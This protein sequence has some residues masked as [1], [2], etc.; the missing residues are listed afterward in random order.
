MDEQRLGDIEKRVYDI[1]QRQDRFDLRIDKLF[2]CFKKLQK[3]VHKEVT[4]KYRRIGS[5]R[6]SKTQ[7]T[8]II[9]S[10]S[11]SLINSINQNWE[12]IGLP[13]D[14]QGYMEEIKME[15]IHPEYLFM[16]FLIWPLGVVLK[17]LTSIGN[18]W[19]PRILLLFSVIG[20]A[21][22]GYTISPYVGI[23]RWGD[24]IFKQGFMQGFFV[25]SAAAKLYDLKH[26]WSK[27]KKLKKEQINDI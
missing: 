27:N 9:I 23:G 17:S 18:G 22:I 24:A 8:A 13:W 26:G 25:S 19:I 7:I 1:E 21:V 3:F 16:V 10:L 11:L 4:D 2:R 15:W 14:L 5:L 6:V 20:C 12:L